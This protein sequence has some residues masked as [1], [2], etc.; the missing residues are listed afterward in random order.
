MSI[1]N[2]KIFLDFPRCYKSLEQG[3]SYNA[4]GEMMSPGC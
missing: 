3:N 2:R 4:L 1:K